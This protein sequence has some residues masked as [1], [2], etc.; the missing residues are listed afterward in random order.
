MLIL[1][2]GEGFW[3][4]ESPDECAPVLYSLQRRVLHQTETIEAIRHAEKI[5]RDE[6]AIEPNGQRRLLFTG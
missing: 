1:A 6:A 2:D 5:M 4:A 3:L